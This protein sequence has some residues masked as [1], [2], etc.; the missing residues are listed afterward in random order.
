VKKVFKGKVDNGRIVLKDPKKYSL[1][2][3]SLNNKDI[4][5]TVGKPSKTRSNQEN[6]YYWGVVIKIL[7]D[8]TGYSDNEMHD[9]LRMLFLLDRERKVPTL[10]STTSLSTVQFE[11]YMS[12]VRAWASSD[13]DVYIPEPNE[14][15]FE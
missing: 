13:L 12:K 6:R 15:D 9:A 11:E 4:E 10:I 5:L 3:W 8:E 14:V 7:S 1:V 2:V